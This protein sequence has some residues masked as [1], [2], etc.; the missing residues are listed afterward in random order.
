[1]EV[2]TQRFPIHSWR[3]QKTQSTKP[4][5][6]LPKCCD[7]FWREPQALFALHY[8]PISQPADWYE[9]FGLF[10]L[11]RLTLT[12]A[13]CCKINYHLDG[14]SRIPRGKKEK[15]LVGTNK[16]TRMQRETIERRTTGPDQTSGLGLLNPPNRNP[17]RYYPDPTLSLT[18]FRLSTSGIRELNRLLWLE[19]KCWFP[20]FRICTRGAQC[21]NHRE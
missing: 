4:K 1:M 6:K 10:F 3:Q 7:L 15:E 19:F 5:W 18:I 12:R 21:R 8:R 20:C 9:F 16:D 17:K 13:N 11:I 2:T 14:Q